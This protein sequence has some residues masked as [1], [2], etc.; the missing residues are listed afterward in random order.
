M[1]SFVPCT[2]PESTCVNQQ[3]SFGGVSGVCNNVTGLCICPEGYSGIDLLAIWNDCHIFEEAR[4]VSEAM[5]LVVNLIAMFLVIY[6]IARLLLSWEARLTLVNGVPWVVFPE[7]PADVSYQRQTMERRKRRIFMLIF[8]NYLSFCLIGISFQLML[9]GDPMYSVLQR[10]NP[11]GLFLISIQIGA[12]VVALYMVLFAW[13]D[14]LPSFR[15]FSRMFPQVRTAFLVRY[16]N[17]IFLAVVINCALTC[18]L[19]FGVFFIYSLVRPDHVL[20]LIIPWGMTLFGMELSIYMCILMA[21][22]ILLL[23]LVKV[24]SD[25]SSGKGG[26]PRANGTLSAEAKARFREAKHTIWAMFIVTMICGPVAVL[27]C[28]VMAWHPF[29]LANF[30][31][32]VAVFQAAGACVAIFTVYVFV[33]RMHYAAKKPADATALAPLGMERGSGDGSISLGGDVHS[34]NPKFSF[35]STDKSSMIS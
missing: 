1:S 35:I 22:C 34:P 5:A 13:F 18:T 14:A 23:R 24:F 2:D 12:I 21:V 7:S 10:P 29:A 33:F 8:A 16:P 4:T 27:L 28:M 31:F 25:D 11:L 9:L 17:F 20:T 19:S 15:L 30:F 32:F 26:S 6:G 3:Y